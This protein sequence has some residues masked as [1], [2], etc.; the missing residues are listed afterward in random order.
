[1]LRS[2]NCGFVCKQLSEPEALKWEVLQEQMNKVLGFRMS[3]LSH[4]QMEK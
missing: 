3:N 4:T 2:C 1:M